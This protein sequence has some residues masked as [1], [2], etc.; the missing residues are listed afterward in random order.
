M[1]NNLFFVSSI[2]LQVYFKPETIGSRLPAEVQET[3]VIS[4]SQVHF[5]YKSKIETNNHNS[6]LNYLLEIP[7]DLQICLITA[8]LVIFLLFLVNW[9][10]SFKRLGLADF[11]K[12]LL[13]LVGMC[14]GI[15]PESFELISQRLAHWLLVFFI[16]FFFLC[17]LIK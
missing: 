12:R 9:L 1:L 15:A 13:D 11:F 16:C 3:R 17:T 7:S 4:N 5:F 14:I 10:L 8:F 6:V 2:R